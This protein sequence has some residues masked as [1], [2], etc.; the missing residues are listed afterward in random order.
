[1]ARTSNMNTV[2]CLLESVN[3]YKVRERVVMVSSDV[4]DFPSGS[5]ITFSWSLLGRGVL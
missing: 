3:C 1:M 2:N 5:Q 4:P